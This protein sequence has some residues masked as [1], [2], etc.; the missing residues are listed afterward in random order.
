M[1]AWSILVWPRN[2]LLSTTTRPTP[3]PIAAMW[4]R[5]TC[6]PKRFGASRPLWNDTAAT[7]SNRGRRRR[8][9]RR[10]PPSG[11]AAQSRARRRTPPC[12]TQ[13]LDLNRPGDRVHAAVLSVALTGLGRC[14]TPVTPSRDRRRWSFSSSAPFAMRRSFRSVATRSFAR[15]P[16]GKPVVGRGKQPRRRRP[17][18][19]RTRRRPDRLTPLPSRA[20]KAAQEPHRAASRC[21]TAGRGPRPRI[22]GVVNL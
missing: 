17:G 11:V 15:A 5:I 19:L 22:G 1:I 6:K 20:L 16:A 4:M 9:V 3:R 13:L 12:Q 21:P 14:W 8:K 18:G 2:G 7:K 10:R